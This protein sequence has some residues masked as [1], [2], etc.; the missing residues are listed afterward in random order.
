MGEQK[1]RGA[2]YTQIE[3]FDMPSS[4]RHLNLRKYFQFS[5]VNTNSFAVEFFEIGV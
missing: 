1:I 4:C 5:L 2:P 3:I